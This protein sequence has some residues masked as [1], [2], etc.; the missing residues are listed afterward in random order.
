MNSTIINTQRNARTDN[1][2]RLRFRCIEWEGDRGCL[3]D[4]FKCPFEVTVEDLCKECAGSLDIGEYV[5]GTVDGER[6]TN[7]LIETG[8]HAVD[9]VERRQF[10]GVGPYGTATGWDPHR[11]SPQ[12]FGTPDSGSR[13]RGK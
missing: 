9:L 3:I 13:K 10:S 8:P 5:S 7:I 11:G 4:R 6:V 12:K 2:M 1:R